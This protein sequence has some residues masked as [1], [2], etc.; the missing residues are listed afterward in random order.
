MCPSEDFD[1]QDVQIQELLS[2]VLKVKTELTGLSKSLL[3]T[4]ESVIRHDEKSDVAD[5]REDLSLHE[6]K[7]ELSGIRSELSHVRVSLDAV[8][9]RLAKTAED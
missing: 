1:Y 2:D 9:A 3:R 5:I 4:K 6:M 8:L 7:L